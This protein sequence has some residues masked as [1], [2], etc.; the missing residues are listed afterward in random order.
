MAKKLDKPDFFCSSTPRTSPGDQV[1]LH[2]SLSS[3]SREKAGSQETE[4]SQ[5]NPSALSSPRAQSRRGLGSPLFHIAGGCP[6]GWVSLL[7]RESPA[8]AQGFLR[9]FTPPDIAGL[10]LTG[11]LPLALPGSTWANPEVSLPSGDP[12]L[13]APPRPGPA[14]SSGLLPLSLPHDPAR[15]V[16]AFTVLIDLFI[17]TM[18]LP[19]CSAM[20][21]AGPLQG[22]R[23]PLW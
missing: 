3:H 1:L 9:C 4:L 22:Q 10:A 7:G 14:L 16:E 13:S 5:K 12:V 2:F 15:K 6:G 11:V 8:V 19:L 20:V 21:R 23:K 18:G 17:C